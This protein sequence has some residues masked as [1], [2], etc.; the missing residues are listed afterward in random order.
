MLPLQIGSSYFL[1]D[2]PSLPRQLRCAFPVST[3]QSSLKFRKKRKCLAQLG[4][5]LPALCYNQHPFW[6]LSASVVPVISI[7]SINHG[8]GYLL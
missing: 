1:S 4:L 3:P 2:C 5:Q 7:L 6:V 8:K